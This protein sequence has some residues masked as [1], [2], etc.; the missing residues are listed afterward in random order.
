MKKLAFVTPWYGD[1]IPGGAEM[2]LRSLI[3]HLIPLGVELEVLTT[4]VEKFTSDWN[5]NYHKPGKTIE[6]GIVVH[7]FPVRKRDTRLF[8][9]INIKLMNNESISQQEEEQ[10]MQEMVNSPKLYKYIK[11]NKDNYSL[12]VFIPYMFGTT[13]YGCQIVPEKS[14][15]IPCF[16]NESY[17]Y[18]SNFRKV[19]HNVA[20]MIF[21]ANPEKKLAEK[22]YNV[23]G[24]RFITLGLGIDS[25]D[26]YNP[27]RFRDKYKIYEPFILYA[28]RK[29]HGK[30]VEQLIYNFEKY[31]EKYGNKLKLVLIGGGNIE[32]KSENIIDLG[33][34]PAQDKY[35]AYAAASIFCNPSAMESFSIVIMES[36]LAKTP[37]LVNG[38]CDV[39]RDFV[40][41]F[42]AG[43][44]YN[45]TEEFI[46][47]VEYLLEN[48]E[49][50]NQMGNNGKLNVEENFSWEIITKKYIDYFKMMS[51]M[52]Q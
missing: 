45:N 43:L 4:C 17:A 39:T 24:D 50:S 30:K 18:M 22:L 6:S 14:I 10:F 51:E 23:K 8:G 48:Q 44:Y 12:F 3:K 1:N 38:E 26:E 34:V 27:Q 2:E 52:M 47:C 35:D 49:I 11:D 46:K 40:I 29:D 9:E 25:I 5:I 19:F 20:G 21:N 41:N 36:W 16:H 42:Q 28:G 32:F 7:R 37:V 33:F 13:Y 31:E 15:L